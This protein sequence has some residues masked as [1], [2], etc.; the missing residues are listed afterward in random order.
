MKYF[1]NDCEVTKEQYDQLF[2]EEVD[3]ANAA[4]DTLPITKPVKSKEVKMTAETQPNIVEAPAKQ[5]KAPKAGSKTAR[6]L[7]IVKSIGLANKQKCIEAIM[8][9]FQ[10]TKSNANAYIFN[11]SKKLV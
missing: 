4:G 8:A 5:G 11:V 1:I 2:V 3:L 7:E 10:T 6:A 9:E